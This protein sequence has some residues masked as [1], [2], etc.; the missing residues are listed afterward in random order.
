MVIRQS[1]RNPPLS[2]LG[3]GPNSNGVVWGTST[4]PMK[5]SQPPRSS[6]S[7]PLQRRAR[8]NSGWRQ[9][10]SP[11]A[12]SFIFLLKGGPISLQLR[13]SN[14]GL[15]RPRVARAKETN[16]LPF[17]SYTGRGARTAGLTGD[18]TRGYTVK[19]FFTISALNSSLLPDTTT[20]PLAITTYFSARRAAKW[21]PCST[22][23]MPK[24]LEFLNPIITS[25]I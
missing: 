12:L 19:C 22:N 14:E 4:A 5:P 15:P 9:S 8:R 10:G 13:A 23:K 18:R 3:Q 7:S 20:A 17:P 24:R 16:G 25:S 1:I 11:A 21:S 6:L 2:Q